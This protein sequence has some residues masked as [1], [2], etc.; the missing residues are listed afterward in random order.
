MKQASSRGK[1]R[2]PIAVVAVDMDDTLLNNRLEIG[3]RTERAIAAVR[4]LGVKVVLATGR[5]YCS[6]RPYALRLRLHGPII[7]YN[8]ALVKTVAGKVLSHRPLPLEVARD[9]LER[10]VEEGWSLHAYVDDRMFVSEINDAVRYYMSISGRPAYPVGDLREFLET[11]PTKLL[12]VTETP[13]EAL[14]LRD[15][16][17]R[18]MGHRMQVSIS[19]ARFVE[20]TRLGVSKATALEDVAQYY[21]V[22]LSRIMAIGDGFNDLDMIR[23]AG[24]GVA[25]AN[26]PA[27]VREAA[28]HVTSSNEEEGVAL[29]LERW[30]LGQPGLEPLQEGHG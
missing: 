14:E 21:Q 26:A 10:A 29:A 2:A 12:I 30:V 8:G 20:L 17:Q 22:P 19:K 5:M 9:V 1:V 3:P 15:E 16:L 18:W 11:D 27:E 13:E 23:A 28:D 6:A 4:E 7:A 24:L 25:V